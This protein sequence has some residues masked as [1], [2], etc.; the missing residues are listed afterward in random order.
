MRICEVYYIRPEVASHYFGQE[1]KIFRLFKEQQNC[2]DYLKPIIERQINYITCPIPAMKIERLVQ[3]SL[4]KFAKYES[5]SFKHFIEVDQGNSRAQLSISLRKMVII[6]EGTLEAETIFFEIIRKI[7][8]NFL[9]I[10][11]QSERYGWL[12]PIKEM[13]FV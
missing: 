6:S 1:I 5:D 12:N 13:K 3:R 8:A 9:A 7:A 2:S 11:L 4:K 10:D